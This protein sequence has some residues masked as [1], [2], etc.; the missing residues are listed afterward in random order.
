[1]FNTFNKSKIKTL[2]AFVIFV[3]WGI[4]LSMAQNV[5]IKD[6]KVVLD[7]KD[8]L[9]YEKINL[10]QHSFYTLGD[11]EILMLKISNNGTFDYRADDY[12]I[13][14]FL[15]LK[16]KVQSKSFTHIYAGLG[17]SFKKNMEKVITWLLKEKVIDANGNLNE[18]KVETFVEKYHEKAE[19]STIIIKV[20]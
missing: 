14:H 10:V 16:V 7:G 9:K 20:R 17:L 4:S 11:D 6:N 19:E 13:L 5:E 15:T 18:A 12:F 1:M 3:F 8:I 2:I